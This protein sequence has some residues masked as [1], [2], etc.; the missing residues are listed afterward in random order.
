LVITALFLKDF[1]NYSQASISFDTER[2]IIVGDNAQ[3]KTNLLEA[4]HVL[5]VS[6]SQRNHRDA[7]LIRD[8][9]SFF[10]VEGCFRDSSHR[11]MR[12]CVSSSLQEGKSIRINGQE[13]GKATDLMAQ[14]GAVSFSSQ[15]GRLTLG[16]PHSRRRFLDFLLLQTSSDY[17]R[18]S[19]E[20]RRVIAHRNRLLKTERGTSFSE[21]LEIWEKEL[22]RVGVQIMRKRARLVSGI[23]QRADRYYER[24]SGVKERFLVS[25]RPAFLTAEEEA[26][27]E[28]LLNRL[29]RTRATDRRLGYTTSGPHRDDVQMSIDGKD[30]RLFGSMGQH[31]TAV[32]ALKL[33]EADVVA[34]RKRHPPILL[35]DDVFTELDGNR[36]DRLLDCLKGKG[37]LFMTACT[38]GCLA[39]SDDN[40]KTLR[41]EKGA[42]R[43]ID[44]TY[45]DA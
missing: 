30:L 25:Y 17:N 2:N 22:A 44:E 39:L 10:R 6:R 33:A 18:D 1:R 11:A 41:C 27:E 20:Y 12:V 32:V 14:I 36:T 34:E 31:R 4:I 8:G 24:V 16:P 42:V 45:V 21:E 29:K 35:F 26:W 23:Q 5:C 15:E 37:Q 3:G 28:L 13:V 40:Y 7:Y 43:S 38:N 19:M 9:A